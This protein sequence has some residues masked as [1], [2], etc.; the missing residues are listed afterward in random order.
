MVFIATETIIIGYIFSDGVIPK[1]FDKQKYINITI[2]I[3]NRTIT[4]DKSI[5][6]Q[7]A[8]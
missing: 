6:L 3:A 8:V 2:T 4:L 7:G 5:F 1:I